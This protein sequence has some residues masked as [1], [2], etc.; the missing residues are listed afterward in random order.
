MSN[1][2]L[3]SDSSQSQ[4]QQTPVAQTKPLAVSK[5]NRGKIFAIRSHSTDDIYISSTCQTLARRFEG[6]KKNFKQYQ[7]TNKNFQPV[8]DIVGRNDC[9]IELLEHFNC[10][11]RDELKARENFYIRQTQ[12]NKCLNKNKLNSE[13]LNIYLCPCGG[14]YTDKLFHE[15]ENKHLQYIKLEKM[16]QFI[17][18]RK[19]RLEDLSM[20]ELDEYMSQI[21]KKF[22]ELEYPEQKL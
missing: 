4:Q 15:Q 9:Y 13:M 8:Y 2:N 18:E 22:I 12:S 16:K 20:E 21:N 10:S 1:I 6:I 5:W 3:V 19:I 11:S 7:K 17:S 14:F